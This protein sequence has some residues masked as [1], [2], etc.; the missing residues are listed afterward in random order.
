MRGTSQLRKPH[1]FVLVWAVAGWIAAAANAA[2]G[3]RGADVT[4]N[5]DILPILQKHCQV[6]HRPGEI[7]PMSFLTYETT[8]PWARAIKAAVLSGKMPPWSADP[9]YGHFSNDRRLTQDEIGALVNWVNSDAPQGETKDELPAVSWPDGW[10]AQ[11]DVVAAMPEPVAIPAKGVMELMYVTLPNPFKKDVWVTSIEIRPG[12]RGVV[13][14]ADFFVVPHQPGVVYGV[15]RVKETARDVDGVALERISLEDRLGSSLQGWTAIYVPGT[16]P[17]DFGRHGGAKLLPA[18]CDFVLQMH[19]T[20]NGVATADQT[21]VG[22]ILAKEPPKRQFVTVL[23]TPPR[24]ETE[25]RIPAGDPNWETHTE[26]VFKKDAELVW[27]LPH[28]HLRGKDMT[29][30]LVYPSGE[31][32][33]LLSVKY[34]F[35]WQ[36]GYELEKPIHVP[37][38]TK[39]E[40]TAHFDNS[41]ENRFNPNPNQNVYWGDQT[42]EEMM[43]PFFGVL[44]GKN[45]MAKQIVAYP[46]EFARAAK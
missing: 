45:T 6:C 24:D 36:M 22:F 30:R 31:S 11:P 17:V 7:A 39:L 12:N 19:Y 26:V 40:V 5:R 15:P 46:R 38:G 43:I 42:W 10:S 27:F 4:F 37:K 41:A 20:P 14:H 9:R 1:I 13:H 44:V 28:M 35:A 34:D 33:I 3:A 16:A 25:F 32:Q 8:R 2:A 23:I 18:D 21:R 29:Y